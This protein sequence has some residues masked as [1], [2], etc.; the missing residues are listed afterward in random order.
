MNVTAI[1]PAYNPD[2]KFLVVIEG[3]VQAG[4]NHIIVVNDG[5]DEKYKSLFDKV[6]KNKH[7]VLL[8]HEENFGKGRAL[9]T[10]FKYFIK[11]YRDDIGVVTLDADNQHK[12]KDV[13]N[14]VKSL[15]EHPNDLILG[16]RNFN[17]ENVPKKSCY[18]NKLTSLAFKVFCGLTISDTQT[19]LR[20]I[21]TYFAEQLINTVGERFEFETNMLLETKE[22]KIA[23]REVPIETVYINGNTSSNF[24]PLIDSFS[25]YKVIAKFMCSSFT[26]ILCDYALFILLNALFGFLAPAWSLLIATVTAR[27]TSSFLNFNLNRK[28]VFKSKSKTRVILAKYYTLAV[29]LIILS[30][31]GILFLSTQVMVPEVVAKM[32]IDIL[33]FLIS[34]RIQ[35]NWVFG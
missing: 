10:A 5:T 14:C 12:V 25:I 23:I 26:S 30:Y 22:Y 15:Q 13:L 4:F 33:L 11:H 29:C 17:L 32:L 34:F 8:E 28:L 16:V 24:N 6:R 19:G 21:P 18:G 7:C 3:L 1:I 35:S 20:A 31:W 9:K 27:L 2:K